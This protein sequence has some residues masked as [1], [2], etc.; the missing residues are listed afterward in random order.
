MPE[1]NLH[2]LSRRSLNKHRTAQRITRCAQRLA[3][4]HGYDE[5][6]LDQ[7]ADAAE[8]SRRTLFNYFPTKLDA[9]LGDG[10][11]IDAA[12]LATFKAGGPTGVLIDDCVEM[13]KVMFDDPELDR[14]AMVTVTQCFE[15]NPKLT[16]E[17]LQRARHHIGEFAG[18]IGEREDLPPDHPRVRVTIAT[19]LAL[20]EVTIQQF[21]ADE[22][23]HFFNEFYAANLQVA[24]DLLGR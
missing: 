4:D 17:A 14:A 10:P 11:R 7:L 9:V 21:V 12:T 6:T 3:A 18:V 13:V 16:H 23:A 2:E 20:V 5:F 22:G 1:S 8:V 15:R 19:L 24:H